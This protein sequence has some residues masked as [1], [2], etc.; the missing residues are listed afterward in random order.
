MSQTASLVDTTLV[1][2]DFC[3][4]FKFNILTYIAVWLLPLSIDELSN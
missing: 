3:R 4:H 2:I 1:S